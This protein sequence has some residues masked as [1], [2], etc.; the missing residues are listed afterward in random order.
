[1]K[2][3]ETRYVDANN[4]P[5]SAQ[6]AYSEFVQEC[7]LHNGEHWPW[8][9]GEGHDSVAASWIGSEKCALIDEALR[10]V[11]KDGETINIVSSW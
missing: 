2:I 4:F 8:E 9:V 1:M 11:L 7:G 3:H 10:S 6:E 5:E